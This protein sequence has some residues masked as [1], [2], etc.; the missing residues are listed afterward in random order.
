MIAALIAAFAIGIAEYKSQLWEYITIRRN[1]FW[2][3]YDLL[4]FAAILFTWK[5]GWIRGY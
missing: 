3:I 4:M 2:F 5:K 1:R